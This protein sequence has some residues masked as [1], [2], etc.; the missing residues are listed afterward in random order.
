MP[1]S[2]GGRGGYKNKN[3]NNNNSKDAGMIEDVSFK[4]IIKKIEMTKKLRSFSV[5]SIFRTPFY[6]QYL[7]FNRNYRETKLH[8]KNKKKIIIF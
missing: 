1:S 8:M 4:K 7:L 3:N 5:C 2:N 6:E